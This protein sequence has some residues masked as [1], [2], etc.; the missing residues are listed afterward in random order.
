MQWA[1]LRHSRSLV[2]HNRSDVEH[3]VGRSLSQ[4]ISSQPQQISVEH[5]VGRSPVAD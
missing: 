4:Q 5:A 1:D 3:A 2:S